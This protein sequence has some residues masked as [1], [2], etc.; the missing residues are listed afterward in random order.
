MPVPIVTPEL[1]REYTE[2]GAWQDRNLSETVAQLP[3]DPE[4]VALVDQHESVS[5]RQ[6]TARSRA[7]A[8]WLTGH[9]GGPGDV[10]GMQASSRAV[11]AV[12]HLACVVADMIFMPI[13]DHFTPEER[14]H[15]VTTSKARFFVLPDTVADASEIGAELRASAP[16]LAFVGSLHAGA[17][18][19]NF[20]FAAACAGDGEP[21]A[22]AQRSDPNR[23]HLAM[24]S[25]G[26]TQLPK[27]SLWSDNNLWFFLE[28]FR[29]HIGLTAG[30]TALQIAPAQHRVDRVRLPGAG[31]PAQRR[32]VRSDRAVVGSRRAGPD[33][34]R[35]ADDRVG[36]TDADHQDDER[37]GALTAGLLE[38]ARIQQCRRSARG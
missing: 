30:D 37:A 32:D 3:V 10:L 27:V 15:L 7:L 36:G 20:D 35:A 19:T 12:A 28:Q 23:P 1:V 21:G 14:R 4:K 31:A 22:P 33:R 9:G 5:Y 25:S 17:T 8:A 26:T 29:L 18:G 38:P 24:V 34:K 2:A 11:L 13:S 16:S 6:L